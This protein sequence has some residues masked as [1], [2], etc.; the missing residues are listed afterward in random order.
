VDFCCYFVICLLIFISYKYN[1]YVFNIKLEHY[2]KYLK[3]SLFW[4]PSFLHLDICSPVELPPKTF[5]HPLNYHPRHL[6]THTIITLDIRSP[7]VLTWS[8]WE[9]R[10]ERGSL[11]SILKHTAHTYTTG[12]DILASWHTLKKTHI[13]SGKLQQKVNMQP[14]YM[15][16]L[17]LFWKT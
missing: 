3:L 9:S 10:G 11:G 12:V 4:I 6:F 17:G 1:K 13:F 15:L 8:P 5:V 2:W 14:F 16:K 7:Y